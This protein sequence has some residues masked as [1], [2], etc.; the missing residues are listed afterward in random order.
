MLDSSQG[1]YPVVLLNILQC[2]GQMPQSFS[3]R[4]AQNVNGVEVEMP[5]AKEITNAFGPCLQSGLDEELF[6][7]SGNYQKR[8]LICGGWG[9]ELAP[10]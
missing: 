8:Y 9:R 10:T 5:W 4:P 3:P 7:Q 6:L 2:T 1:C